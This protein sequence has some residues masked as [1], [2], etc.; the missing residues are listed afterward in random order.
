MSVLKS[1]L[2]AVTSFF[3]FGQ[4]VS[5]QEIIE[6]LVINSSGT[7]HEFKVEVVDT[8]ESRAKGLMFRE[9]L[10]PNEGMLFDFHKVAPV[11]FWMRNTLIPLDMLFIK[12]DGEIAHIHENAVPHDET[13]VPSRFPV[14]FVLEIAGG[15]SAKLGL[16]AG[17]TIASSRVK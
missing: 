13:A 4:F 3:M 1:F 17:D 9:H 2:I 12:A 6:T 15:R 5:A 8:N 11:A 7:Q 16:K 14:Q 10:D